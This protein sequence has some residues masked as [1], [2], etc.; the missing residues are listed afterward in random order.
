MT[1]TVRNLN[2]IKKFG[3]IATKTNGDFFFHKDDFDGHWDDLVHDYKKGLVEVTFE[4][5]KSDKGPRAGSVRRVSEF[6][7]D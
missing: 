3:F 6:P 7:I 5:V 2:T 4:S 1:G